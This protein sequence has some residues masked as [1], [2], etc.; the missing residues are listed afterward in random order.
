MRR[1]VRDLTFSRFTG[2][3]GLPPPGRWF[4]APTPPNLRTQLSQVQTAD[5]AA[6]FHDDIIYP[7]SIPFVLV[8]L[9][10]FAAVWTGVTLQAVLLGLALYVVRM[11]GVTAGFH[12]YFS[13]RSYRTS[14][15]G[16][17]LLA[18]LCQTSAQ[19]GL[20]WWAAMHRHHHKHSDT[21]LD[22]HSPRHHGFLYAHVGWIFAR[23]NDRP[24]YDGVAD[25]TQ[26]PELRW[27]DRHP[28]LVAAALA[29]GCFALAGWPGLVVAFFW[30]TVL[31]YHGTFTINSLAHVHGR[32]RYLTG[33]DSRNNWWLA[34]I[35][36]GEGW[37]NNHHAYQSAARQGFRWWEID[38]TYYGLKVL[39]GLRVIHDLRAPPEELVRNELRLGRKVVET[40]A[41]DL[42][43]SFPI[44]RMVAQVRGAWEHTPTLEELRALARTKQAQLQAH[45]AAMN[46]PSLPSLEEMRRRAQQMFAHAPSVSL[47]EIAQRAREL[48]LEAVS[49]RLFEDLPAPA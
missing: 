28:Y 27:L 33:D 5:R 9:A 29:A 47:E 24:D 48:V 8:H 39:S 36:L 45:L 7:D 32:Q 16:Q 26:Y 13:H 41:R 6:E 11:F 22:V 17:F 21:E 23:R 37:H 43:A 20:I 25:L 42:A 3:V 35:T 19:R 1:S 4:V 38:I 34:L 49:V 30:S 14:R 18:L 12:R 10:C 31:L 44:E 2:Y 40:V 46:L 15:V